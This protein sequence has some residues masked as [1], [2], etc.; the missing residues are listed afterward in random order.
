[1]TICLARLYEEG[2]GVDK[3]TYNALMWREKAAKL[4]DI[5]AMN[6]LCTLFVQYLTFILLCVAIHY[7]H[8]KGVPKDINNGIK[9]LEKAAV[10]GSATSAFNL[11]KHFKTLHIQTFTR[12]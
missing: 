11:G 8:G 12:Y 3:N 6:N 10:A 9:W 4:G 7:I 2:K 5:T 1:M